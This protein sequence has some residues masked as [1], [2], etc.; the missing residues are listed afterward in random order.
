VKKAFAEICVA[1]SSASF[2]QFAV[3]HEATTEPLD[4]SLFPSNPIKKPVNYHTVLFKDLLPDTLYAY[5]VGD[6]KKRWSEWI[7]FRT[8]SKSAKP[9]SFTYFG[10]SQN[11]L[12]TYFSRTIRMAYKTAPNASFAIHAGDLVN[13]AHNDTEWAEWFKAG[14]FIHAQWTGVPVTGNHEYKNIASLGAGTN[15]AMQWR[16]QF[17]LP[18]ES[19][20]PESLHETVYS[21]DYQG[22]QFIVLNSNKEIELQSKYLEQELSKPNYRW[23]VV[24]YHHSI[25]SPSGRTSENYKLMLSQWVPL[26]EKHNVDLVLQGHDHAYVRSQM[27]VRKNQGKDGAIQTMYVTSVSGPKQYPVKGDHLEAYRKQYGL[28]STR[29]AEHTQFFHVIKVDGNRLTYQAFTATGEIY[30]EAMLTK[31]FASGSKQ[32]AEKIPDLAERTFANTIPYHF[33]KEKKVEAQQEAAKKY[34][35]SKQILIAAHRGGYENALKNKAPENSLANLEI[36]IAKGY[37]V[38]ES[39]VR[40][41]KDGVF[42]IVHDPEIE[43]ETTGQGAVEDQ[44]WEELKSLRKRYRRFGRDK[45][46][47]ESQS[48]IATFEEFLIAAKRRILFKIDLKS[49]T[50]QH[51]EELLALTAKHEMLSH[52]IF[53]VAYKDVGLFKVYAANSKSFPANLLM[54]KTDSKE[55]IDRVVAE[56]S[57]ATIEVTYPKELT[58]GAL[59]LVKYAAAKGVLVEQHAGADEA[60]WKQQ[61]NAGVKMFHTTKP[62]A[63]KKFLLELKKSKEAEKAK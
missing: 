27:P 46:G 14:Q 6:G 62:A 8:A 40:R 57:P 19:T 11:D 15:V 50:K 61:L 2:S 21:F 9:F 30:D 7:Q 60:E 37:Q 51:F 48:R 5:R 36:A 17:N 53:R 31:D 42:V 55:K 39:D 63:M 41:T 28:Q 32:L 22:V 54:F 24:T 56:F 47:P 43:K 4:L 13:R 25:F 52:V 3:R 29:K 16:P 58:P 33:P 59:E 20:L 10:D 18:I 38:Y 49:D 12:L 34:L 45:L 23:R 44:T 1:T 26:F 35:A